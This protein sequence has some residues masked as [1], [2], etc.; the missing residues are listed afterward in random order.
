MENNLPIN[1]YDNNFQLVLLPNNIPPIFEGD[2][3]IARRLVYVNFENVLNNP[4]ELN[5]FIAEGQQHN[6]RN[7]HPEE[8]NDNTNNENNYDD[9]PQKKIKNN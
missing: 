8:N 5:I 1:V 2:V 3:S 9:R 4:N 6:G 7:L